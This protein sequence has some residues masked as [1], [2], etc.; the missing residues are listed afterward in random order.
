MMGPPPQHIQYVQHFQ[1]MIDNTLIEW[2]IW[3]IIVDIATGFCKS[4]VTHRTTSK[5][6]T[7]GLIKHGIVI[8][9]TLT[10]YP[11]LDICGLKQAGD[12]LVFFFFLFYLVS[13]IENWGQ[14]GLPLPSWVKDHVYKLSKDYLKEQED[15]TD[16]K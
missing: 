2:L 1:S 14:M 10:A 3:A 7:E 16:E 15:N 6:G 9:V 13:I 12:S 11:M 8:I 4:L 5:K